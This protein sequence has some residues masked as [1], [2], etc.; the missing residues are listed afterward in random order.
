ML[1]RSPTP[2]TNPTG[3]T[4]TIGTS[5]QMPV[6]AN[7]LILLAATRLLVKGSER[8][9]KERAQTEIAQTAAQGRGFKSGG[10][11]QRTRCSRDSKKLR[12]GSRYETYVLML[13]CIRP[14]V[15]TH[16]SLRILAYVLILR[17]IRPDVCMHM[18]LCR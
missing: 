3:P 11:K 12:S 7:F 13:R 2:K 5:A 17:Y 8:K 9:G 10:Q 15:C 14:Y 1:L 16:M 18:P 6:P 4:T